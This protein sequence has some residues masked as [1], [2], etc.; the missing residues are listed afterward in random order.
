V[1]CLQP[2]RIRPDKDFI[3]IAG[4]TSED[5]YVIGGSQ[6]FGLEAESVIWIDQ[7][8]MYLKDYLRQHGVPD[9]FLGWVNTGFVTAV[10]R[11]G[12]MLVGYGAGRRDFQGF[13]VILPDGGR[14]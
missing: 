8:P 13:I 5:G 1:K 6:S 14:P 11:D 2:P 7:E 3:G 9:A 4:G 12:R 10:S